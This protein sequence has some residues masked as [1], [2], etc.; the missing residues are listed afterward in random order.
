MK[1]IIC[2]ALLCALT[3]TLTFALVSCGGPNS[4]EDDAVRNLNAAGY[5]VIS[6]EDTVEGF[7]VDAVLA[8]RGDFN[9]LEA[10]PAGTDFIVIYYFDENEDAKVFFDRFADSMK[11]FAPEGTSYK[12]DRDGDMVYIGTEAAI[13]AT[14][15]K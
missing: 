15:G 12:L 1:K 14:N 5:S 10:P 9:F 4:D 11:E 8:Y 2:T 7:E 13:K 3:L 6:D